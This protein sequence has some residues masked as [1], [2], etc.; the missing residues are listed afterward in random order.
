[1]SP[2]ITLNYT[3]TTQDPMEDKKNPYIFILS[4]Y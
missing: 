3:K 2:N 4:Y 1:M